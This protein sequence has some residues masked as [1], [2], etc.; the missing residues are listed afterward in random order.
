MC[1]VSTAR[2]H[3]QTSSPHDDFL[4]LM[5]VV[6]RHARIVFRHLDKEARDETVSEAIAAAFEAH[7]HLKARDRNPSQ[8]PTMLATFAVLHVKDD[9]HVGGR[10]SSR[11][12]LSRKA[13]QRR[14]FT[15][16]YLPAT[17]RTSF[18]ERY[19]DVGGQRR[20]DILEECLQ[21]DTRTPVPDQVAFKLDF[22][23]FLHTLTERD[24]CMA[25]A[26]AEGHAATQ[27]AARFGLTVGRITQKRQEWRREWHNFQGETEHVAP[28]RHLV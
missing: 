28:T 17:T 19:A 20:Q 27:V 6:E 16:E 1:T 24:R 23:A 9:R 14:G 22:P 5:P 8:F 10:S 26:L 12:A 3:D 15:V 2:G 25:V 11:D 7:I 21:D 4:T 18:E 13:Q